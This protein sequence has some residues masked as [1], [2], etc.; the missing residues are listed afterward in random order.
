LPAE[1]FELERHLALIQAWNVAHGLPPQRP[2]R[3]PK[4]GLINDHAAGFLMATDCSE[5]HICELVSDPGIPELARGRA[6]VEVVLGLL[7][8]ARARGYESLRITT[9]WRGVVALAKRLGGRVDPN[10]VVVSSDS[11]STE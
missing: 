5:T 2:S 1:P 10:L 9:H 11:W 7:S 3:L 6:V 8:I 4:T